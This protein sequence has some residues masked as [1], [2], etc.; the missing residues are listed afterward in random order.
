MPVL[1]LLWAFWATERISPMELMRGQF[2]WLSTPLVMRWG[3]L[4]PWKA[5]PTSPQSI[6]EECVCQSEDFVVAR[7]KVL[8]NSEQSL[9][10][11]LSSVCVCVWV[12]SVWSS[13]LCPSRL[14]C[15]PVKSPTMREYKL[16]VLGSGGVGKSALVSPSRSPGRIPVV[17]NTPESIQVW[18]FQPAQS[19]KT[20][21]GSV[22]SC[23]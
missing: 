3:Y 14:L 2:L 23:F 18:L 6:L 16:V 7:V 4:K 21:E 15:C 9:S 1:V 5:C 20:T 12:W 19:V 13:P 17:F 10:E 8:Q 11:Q 22:V